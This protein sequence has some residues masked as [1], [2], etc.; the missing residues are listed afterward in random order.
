MPDWELL[1]ISK[2]KEALVG[3]HCTCPPTRSTVPALS[4]GPCQG[5]SKWREAQELYPQSNSQRHKRLKDTL[6]TAQQEMGP[7]GR[8]MASRDPE[9]EQHR[10]KPRASPR[11]GLTAGSSHTGRLQ[12]SLSSH[13]EQADSLQRGH[14]DTQPLEDGFLGRPRRHSVL[15]DK[16]EALQE[17]PGK[18]EDVSYIMKTS[19]QSNSSHCN[20]L[21]RPPEGLIERIVSHTL[22]SSHTGV[23]RTQSLDRRLTE[24][25][26]TPDLLNIKKGWLSKLFD[27]GLWKKRWFVLTDQNLRWYRDAVA[28]EVTDF[29][30]EVDLST[31]CDVKEFPVLRNYGFQIHT[32]NGA[33]TL[34]AMTSGIRRHW[35]QA[36]LKNVQPVTAPD[37]TRTYPEE[38]VRVKAGKR[39]PGSNTHNVEQELQT[40]TNSRNGTEQSRSR[41]CNRRLDGRY[42]TFDWS[43]FQR[44]LLPRESTV[45]MEEAA[46]EAGCGPDE[47]PPR[48]RRLSSPAKLQQESNQPGKK[49]DTM[50]PQDQKSVTDGND[51]ANQSPQELQGNQ[52]EQSDCLSIPLVEVSAG[53]QHKAEVQEQRGGSSTIQPRLTEVSAEMLAQVQ[54]ELQQEQERSQ[55]CRHQWKCGKQGLL[56]QLED[57]EQ[58]LCTLEAQL[59]E[60]SEV[61]QNIEKQQALQQ[62]HLKEAQQLQKKLVEV[63]EEA[64]AVS[65]QQ[66]EEDLEM[67][68]ERQEKERHGLAQC[69]ATAQ[70]N[71]QQLERRLHEAEQQAKALLR[72]TQPAGLAGG[73]PVRMLEAQLLLKEDAIENL[74]KTVHLL[75]E[76]RSQLEQHC[77]ELTQQVAKSQAKMNP[78]KEVG[79]CTKCSQQLIQALQ[80]KNKET[81]RVK[82]RYEKLVEHKEQELN[83]ALVKMAALGSSLEETEQR[84]EAK[85]QLLRQLSHG[86][87]Q[88]ELQAKFTHA[89]ERVAELERCHEGLQLAYTDLHK[90][91]A[92]LQEDYSALTLH[93]QSFSVAQMLTMVRTASSVGKPTENQGSVFCGARMGPGGSSEVRRSHSLSMDSVPP[94]SCEASVGNDP[95]GFIAIIRSLEAKLFATEKKLRDIT[96]KLGKQWHFEMEQHGWVCSSNSETGDKSG[97]LYKQ[98]R[99][100]NMWSSSTRGVDLLGRRSQTQSRKQAWA[101][102]S[103]DRLGSDMEFPFLVEGER[104]L[105]CATDNMRQE[106]GFV[107][108]NVTESEDTQSTEVRDKK[109]L[110]EDGAKRFAKTLAFEA[111]LLR[112][113]ALSIRNQNEDVFLNFSEIRHEGE[114]LKRSDE[115][116]GEV[117][118]HTLALKLRVESEFWIEVEKLKIYCKQGEDRCQGDAELAD[119]HFLDSDYVKAEL[120]SA[121]Q[122][123]K[124]LYEVKFQRL[125]EDMKKAHQS[126]HSSKSTLRRSTQVT[127]GLDVDLNSKDIKKEVDCSPSHIQSDTSPPEKLEAD[128]PEDL[129]KGTISKWLSPDPPSYRITADSLLFKQDA[130]A[131]ELETQATFLQH[132]SREVATSL[133][134]NSS[135]LHRWLVA[136]YKTNPCYNK[137][138]DTWGCSQCL[139]EAMVQAQVAYV[140]CRLRAE[141]KII[142][143][144]HRNAPRPGSLQVENEL[145]RKKLLQMQQR[146]A[147]LEQTEVEMRQAEQERAVMSLMEEAAESKRKLELILLEVEKMEDRHEQQVQ[148]L[149]ETFQ[150]RFQELGSPHKGESRWLHGVDMLPQHTTPPQHSLVQPTEKEVGKGDLSLNLAP[151]RKRIQELETQ[152]KGMKQ[153]LGKK[154]LEKSIFHLKEEYQRDLEQL[155]AT[156]EEGFAAMEEA[157]QRAME[158]LRGQHQREVNKL[159]EEREKLLAE[160][161]AATIAAIEAMNKAHR[162]ELEKVQRVQL[163]GRCDAGELD[164]HYE[165]ELQSVHRELDVLSEQYSH[166]CLENTHLGQALGAERLALRRCQ[167]ENRELNARNLELN[168]Q[169]REEVSRLHQS[170]PRE[171]GSAS[172]IQNSEQN[173]LKVLLRMKESEIQC[174]KQELHSLREELQA[175]L[176]EKDHPANKHNREL[177]V[178]RLEEQLVAVT[179]AHSTPL[180]LGHDMRCGS[181]NNLHKTERPPLARRDKGVRSKSLNEGLTAEEC[182]KLFEDRESKRV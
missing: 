112:K 43:E 59:L 155:K 16:F 54:S 148:K 132:L 175:V 127:K 178:S 14:S 6:S 24:S 17:A 25:S 48:G 154:Q 38:K 131:A 22:R 21:E 5:S 141:H 36:I 118:V 130:L 104:E 13:T 29:E 89:V 107:E 172:K 168:K 39:V 66:T 180:A 110:Q 8:A 15:I 42:K 158:E 68:Q 163:N 137:G 81:Q 1:F 116:L 52:I 78:L 31:C 56:A 62:D 80:Q 93:I 23:R 151:L 34:C 74:M 121:V 44:E 159:Q 140:V 138:S 150:Q 111:L 149:E 95:A 70:G 27:R 75:R 156:C 143:D 153:E 157:H 171:V 73:E 147:K 108:D 47:D 33:I 49:E 67:L 76:E 124:L 174:L 126:S 101:P 122:N 152:V 173:E 100:M 57:G 61:L 35:I 53:P 113:M 97:K 105:S 82:E 87:E 19:C 114:N 63:T 119:G 11:H 161:T 50:P 169:L 77:Q 88:S 133:E 120:A 139:Q 71:M 83:E 136:M 177:S 166:K 179:E 26:S 64:H 7:S 58:R 135:G 20:W 144:S 160:E 18:Q 176:R 167:R 30:G 162:Q 146:L 32:K 86:G 165:E 4:F 90:T 37:V 69:L 2:S 10:G 51:L 65:E 170:I 28:E 123:L 55:E 145:L 12:Q 115:G 125:Q 181:R 91:H 106:M 40:L 60:R 45:P 182:M 92:E 98:Q 94:D 3:E 117:D 41:V 99:D 128:S 85:E 142:Q 102:L 129:V 79:P 9:E 164:S 46:S 84:L 109:V 96:A 103:H 72:E 134:W